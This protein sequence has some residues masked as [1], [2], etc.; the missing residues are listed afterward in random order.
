MTA[1][2]DRVLGRREVL[3]T[4]EALLRQG[5]T[6]LLHGPVGIGKTTLLAALKGRA[7][8]AGIPCGH[9]VRTETLSDLTRALCAAHPTVDPAVGGA[10]NLKSRLRLATEGRPCWLLLDGLGAT[11]SAFKGSLRRLRG[12]GAGMVLAADTDRPR[13]HARVRSLGLTRHEIELA[14]L[15]RRTIRALLLRMT[16]ATPLPF[17]LDEADVH[18]L[19]VCAEGMPGRCAW[20]VDALRD[21][22]AWHLGKPRTSWLKSE[23][24]IRAAETYRVGQPPVRLGTS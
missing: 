7:R 9:A 18:D 22:R 15:H 3:A 24:V 14:P 23:A 16:A 21:P 10:Q 19:A 17:G 8:A 4:V 11:G 5:Q 6:V 13:D 12:I 2:E 20:F 1:R